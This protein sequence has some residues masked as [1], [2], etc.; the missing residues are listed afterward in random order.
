MR[1]RTE[2]S[3]GDDAMEDCGFLNFTDDEMQATFLQSLHT[4]RK[5]RLFCDVVLNVENADI[6]AHKNVLASVSP[7][8]MELF[9]VEQESKSHSEDVPSYRL[10]GGICRPA[11]QIL[12]DYA[13]TAKLEVPDVLVKDVYLAAWKL[14]MDRVVK[15]CARHL[16]Q[17][18]SSDTCIEIRSLPGIDKNKGFV[19]E[20]DTFI[21]KT[22]T[23]VSSTADFLQ[24]PCVQ[25]DVLYQTKQEM[26]LVTH[27]SVCRLV[28]DWIKRQ[29]TDE[30]LNL[31]QL[32]ERSH[33]LYLALDNS[34]QDCSDLPP[35]HESESEIVQDYKRLVLKCPANK[36]RRKCL[37]APG[38]PRV[39]LYSRDIGDRETERGHQPEWNFI[40]STKCG[41]NTFLALATVNGV[42]MRISVKLRL[43]SIATQQS[44]T[45]QET[46][47]TCPSSDDSDGKND[48]ELFCEV[49]AM[50][51]PKCGLGVA[52]L[53]GKLLVC[54]GYDRGECLRKVESYCPETNTWA[55]ESNM[56][57]ARG[58]V[59][60]AVIDGTVYAVGGSN[61]TTELDTV[62]CLKHESKKWEKCSRLPLARSNAGVCELNK[63]L[64]C[65][66]GWNGQSGIKQ[67]DVYSPE[68]NKWTSICSL[69]TGRYQA[70]VTAHNGKLWAVGGSD[71][72]NCLGSVE[73]YDPEKDQWT[74]SPSLLTAR[75]GCGLAVFQGKLYAVGGSDGT[76]T[77][78]STEVFDETTKSWILGPSLIIPRSN[79]SVVVVKDK[80]YAI[81]GF[82]GKIFLN[83]MEYLDPNTNEWTTF[84]PQSHNEVDKF[85]EELLADNDSIFS[86]QNGNNNI[87]HENDLTDKVSDSDKQRQNIKGAVKKSKLKN[88]VN[89]HSSDKNDHHNHNSSING[90]A[91]GLNGIDLSSK[92][93]QN[94][95]AES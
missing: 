26:S 48:L 55:H 80:L 29:L 65:I 9:S 14:R 10:N 37:G 86:K 5:H 60:I 84:V 23:A 49:A 11:L 92:Q 38:K 54:G 85:A 91:N 87:H 58:R 32:L 19:Q 66:G 74:Y 90:L 24:L 22:F 64:Y 56:N 42:L 88:G 51:G 36:Q 59:Q 1:P 20:V 3:I 89:N 27:D 39:L 47:Q 57:E 41:E 16:I 35:G 28:L 61:G 31:G 62:E 4:M 45:S 70:G 81:G 94:G 25:I 53:D 44:T 34:L 40:S 7:Y 79:V 2:C 8:F 12:V 93:D 52:D 15:E 13:Y 21:D 17:E 43:N 46:T 18:L 71:A 83:T 76:Q 33:L 30:S 78:S 50:S 75:R 63:K 73:T 77:L 72:W 68:E 95:I 6:H 69:N 67:C 82:S